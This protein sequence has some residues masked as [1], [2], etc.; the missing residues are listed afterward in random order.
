MPIQPRHTITSARPRAGRRF[1]DREDFIGAFKT[2]FLDG[3]REQPRVLVYY[4]VGG[5]GKTT[6]RKELSRLTEVL[7]PGTVQTALD[8]DVANYRDQETALF[9]MRK[10]LHEKHKVQFA[11]FDIAYAV[12]WQRTRP[13]T[14]LTKDKLPMLE[15][16]TALAD[17]VSAAGSLPVVGMIPKLTLLAFKAGGAIHEWWTKRGHDELTGLTDFEPN[18][19]LERLPLYWATSLRDHLADKG[20]PAV[21]FLDT[22]E[23]LWESD[24]TEGVYHLRDDWVR[25]LVAQ[26]PEVLWV[27]CGRERL[28]WEELDPDWTA[29]LDQ[30]LIGGLADTDARSL[31]AACDVSAPAVQQAII[32]GSKGMPYYLDLA[33]DT[34]ST[35]KDR[36]KREPEPADFARTPREVFARFLRNLTLPET[37]TL[38]VL[39]A[40]RFWD[41]GLF[42]LLVKQYHTGYSTTSFTD[43]CRFSFI[44][45]ETGSVTDSGPGAAPPDS[46]VFRMHHVMHDSLQEHQAR[47]LNQ[48]VH[49]F[50]FDYYTSRLDGLDVRSITDRQRVALGEAFYHG[51]IVLSAPAL[52]QWLAP[53]ATEFAAGAEW[54]LLVPLYEETIQLLR[55]TAL[56]DQPRELASALNS[57][58]EL[59]RILGRYTEAEPAFREALAIREQILAPDSEELADTLSGFGLLLSDQGK[60]LE[61]EPL[62]RRALSIREKTLGPEHSDVARSLNNLGR[63][64][65][66][67]CRY[68]DAETLFRRALTIDEKLLGP[69]NIVI[70]ER[71]N[72]LAMLHLAQG[73]YADAEPL[74]RRALQINEQVLGPDHPD[75]AVSLNNL[76]GLYYFQGRLAEVEPLLRRALEIDRKALGA[77][78]PNVA[79]SLSNLAGLLRDQGHYEE[80]EQLYRE[81]LE[82]YERALGS[83]HPDV[84]KSL[85]S[86]ATLYRASRRFEEAEQTFRRALALAEKSLGPDHPESARSL[87]G[88]AQVYSDQGRHA[89]AEPLY[90]RALEIN[91]KVLGSD[92]PD[93]T[94][95]LDN[96]ARTC[97]QTG[98]DTEAATLA[99][100]AQKLRSQGSS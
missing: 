90:R 40:P 92:H 46:R 55:G 69:D 37:E 88:L 73:E 93:L 78:H 89:D 53:I 77:D 91:E 12:Y 75:M 42:E 85:N 30:H 39:S 80:A 68:D 33:I 63:L 72:N 26:L 31:L 64:N 8:F 5:I 59:Y 82:I 84:A 99:E 15:S 22:Y 52:R 95:G 66:F 36:E 25:E 1:T 61:A 57:L 19:I 98:K 81:A 79:L 24:R 51:R 67:L 76:A 23:A 65:W 7:K 49:R 58:A 87:N 20:L 43:L 6:L 18:E 34:Y 86:L 41:Y 16:G 54:N 3:P 83:E 29:C 14:P 47:E 62:E 21:I 100:R 74:Y 35:I 38:K 10:E 4:G 96:L 17:I 11:A 70:A 2:A 97:R 50:M 94:E 32:E 28:R 60:Y 13:Q 71:L 27:V 45:E 44:S 9:A 56:P 48:R